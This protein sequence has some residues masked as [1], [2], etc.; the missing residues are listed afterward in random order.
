L[1]CICSQDIESVI[2]PIKLGF[3]IVSTPE[4]QAF[5]LEVLDKANDTNLI[6]VRKPRI[7]L[8]VGRFSHQGYGRKDAEISSRAMGFTGIDADSQ[9]IRGMAE[10]RG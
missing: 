5:S 10:N 7:M 8:K 6:I 9:F 4:T 3:D 2:E 1:Q